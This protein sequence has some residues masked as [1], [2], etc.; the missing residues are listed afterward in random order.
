MLE[1]PLVEFSN[2]I[3][4]NGGKDYQIM[5]Q[6]VHYSGRETEKVARRIQYAVRDIVNLIIENILPVVQ[7]EFNTNG[8]STLLSELKKRKIVYRNYTFVDDWGLD[9]STR[10]TAEYQELYKKI[11][12]I[13]YSRTNEIRHYIF[14]S[15][16]G[17]KVN[18]EVISY[19]QDIL[20]DEQADNYIESFKI[21]DGKYKIDNVVY[22]KSEAIQFV[23]NAIR[24]ESAVIKVKTNIYKESGFRVKFKYS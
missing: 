16:E 8:V 6:Y 1:K 12:S 7:L 22:N 23:K 10:E 15:N 17:V 20:T 3:K 9:K 11:N 18:A 14:L 21:A 19:K 4:I 5:P 2:D 13:A 24:I